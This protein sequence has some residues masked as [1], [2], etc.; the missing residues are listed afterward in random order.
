MLIW[1][2]VDGIL[3]KGSYPPCLGMADRAPFWQDTL[4]VC[5]ECITVTTSMQSV[6]H[7]RISHSPSIGLTESSPRHSRHF[8]S[9]GKGNVHIL[10]GLSVTS[11]TPAYVP[12]Q[13]CKKTKHMSNSR[14]VFP[15]SSPEMLCLVNK[16]QEN[17]SII[18]EHLNIIVLLWGTVKIC[19]HFLI[20]FITGMAQA[21][22]FLIRGRPWSLYHLEGIIYPSKIQTRVPW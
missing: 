9:F 21:Y 11:V 7:G 3:P 10:M 13:A 6:D 16:I 18:K 15:K 4:V 17:I 1:T 19:F 8:S 5:Y 2:L 22:G 12:V 20:L 14:K